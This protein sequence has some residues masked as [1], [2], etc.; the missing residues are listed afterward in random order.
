MSPF[1]H[2]AKAVNAMAARIR[3]LESSDV[4]SLR[5]VGGLAPPLVKMSQDAFVRARDEVYSTLGPNQARTALDAVTERVDDLRRQMRQRGVLLDYGLDFTVKRLL[6]SAMCERLSAADAAL[7]TFDLDL[8]TSAPQWLRDPD[9]KELAPALVSH[10][11]A[12]A[13]SVLADLEAS[14]DPWLYEPLWRAYFTSALENVGFDDALGS[15]LE[16]SA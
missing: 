3:N 11:G 1:K 7:M 16:L 10:L 6:V 4:S 12:S 15:V 14:G 2:R 9:V 13:F 5:E 8:S